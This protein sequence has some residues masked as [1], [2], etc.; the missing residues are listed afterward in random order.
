MPEKRISELGLSSSSAKLI[1]PPFLLLAMYGASIGKTGISTIRAATN[2]AI[3]WCRPHDDID[4]DFIH[5]Y[6]RYTKKSLVDQ[7]Q[8]G[9]QPNISRSI[10]LEQPIP[11]APVA[12]Q[13]RIV[14]RID[15]LL[16]EIAEGEAAL[17]RARCDLDTWRRALLKAAVTGELTREWREAN[18]PTESGADLVA[19]IRGNGPGGASAARRRNRSAAKQAF[20]TT[21]LPEMPANWGWARLCDLGEIVGGV[22]VDKKRTPSKPADVPYLR[23]ANVQRGHLD[24]SEIKYIRVERDVAVRLQ[25][26]PG[27]LLLNEG[28]D[29][30]KIGRGW[31]W[32]GEVQEC[33]HQNNV[34]RVRLREGINP[35]F[36][37]HYANEMGRRF[38]VEKGKQT[39]NLA[40]IS[41]SKISELPVPVPPAAEASAIL[42][43][44]NEALAAELDC[45]RE[46]SDARALAQSQR[47]SILK[48]AFEGQLVQQDPAD[49]PASLLL[50]RLYAAGAAEP[51]APRRR[52]RVAETAQ[53]ALA[54]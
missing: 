31:V 45:R 46:L 50:A 49:E 54:L 48:A 21:E 44:L 41:L 3:A 8:G 23:V 11:L 24:L 17:E 32:Q 47:Q 30:D 25:L 10:V 20:D 27:D 53:G 36:V 5:F 37:S 28:G 22:T 16:S 40:S 33:I 2:Q 51:A 29:R 26:K 14:Q 35:Y 12:E 4:L 15:E 6:L 52:G 7:G 34:F 42:D 43:R 39:T 1:E 13:R 19:S 18:R 9:A 38:F